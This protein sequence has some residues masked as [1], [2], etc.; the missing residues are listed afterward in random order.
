MDSNK[1]IISLVGRQGSGKTTLGKELAKFL[2]CPHVE[3]SGV[4]REECGELARTDMPSTNKRSEEEPRW[5]ADAMRKHF[6]NTKKAVVVT[7][8]REPHIHEIWEEDGDELVS[9][10]VLCDAEVRFQRLLENGKCSSAKEFIEHELNEMALG[11]LQLE[12]L[13]P[14]QIPTSDDTDPRSIVKAAIK[15]MQEKGVEFK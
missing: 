10:Q 5:L 6:S 4:V 15:V 12:F 1:L 14:Y 11:V 8:V 13:A 2:Q 3:A 7:G 9:F